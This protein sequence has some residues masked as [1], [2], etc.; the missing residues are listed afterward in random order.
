MSSI[1]TNPFAH[2]RFSLEQVTGGKVVKDPG[3]G[4]GLHEQAYS[5]QPNMVML[6]YFPHIMTD[7]WVVSY[8]AYIGNL[9]FRLS[10][11]AE[12]G[13]FRSRATA[14]AWALGEI[15]MLYD[16]ETEKRPKERNDVFRQE[17]LSLIDEARQY[18]INF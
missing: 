11:K 17:L 3:L 8:T 7:M 16:L 15:L 9:T 5:N 14:K 4:V 2:L 12:H 18:I 13:L 10:S 1:K 6:F